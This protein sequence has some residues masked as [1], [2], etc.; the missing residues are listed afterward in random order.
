VMFQ[1]GEWQWELII[2]F[3]DVLK[4]DFGDVHETMNE[5][6]EMPPNSFSLSWASRKASWRKSRKWYFK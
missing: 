4:S 1:E 6:V 5:G 2:C 3:L